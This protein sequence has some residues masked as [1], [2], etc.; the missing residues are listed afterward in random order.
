MIKTL[1]FD[2]DGTLT[3]S[4]EGITKSVAYALQTVC[5]IETP[6]LDTLTCYIGPP[7]VEGFIENHYVDYETAKRCKDVY[8]ERYRETGLFQNEV[9]PNIP[10]VLAH[11]KQQGFTLCVATSKPEEFAVQILEHFGLAQYFTLISGASMDG[12][13]SNKG[14][15]IANTLHRMG[16]TDPSEILMIG[17]RNHDIF[18]A[19]AYDIRVIGVLYGFGSREEFEK[20]QADAIAPNVWDIPQVIAQFQTDA[21]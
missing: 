15:V 10:E 20:A 19:H 7:L 3:N 21:Q 4:K 13:I 8:R 1:F 11:L 2:L 5:G 18:G 12:T 6:D 17:D 9:Y 14:E 16:D